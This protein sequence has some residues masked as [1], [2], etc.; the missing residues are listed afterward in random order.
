MCDESLLILIYCKKFPGFHLVVVA[1]RTAGFF[2]SIEGGLWSCQGEVEITCEFVGGASVYLRVRVS[3]MVCAACSAPWERYNKL[4]TLR[5]ASFNGI[6]ST[7]GLFV[8]IALPSV[9]SPCGVL[10]FTACVVAPHC[11]FPF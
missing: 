6:P 8:S 2:Q 3:L 1:I 5:F 7:R 10:L 9:S 11:Q 4:F